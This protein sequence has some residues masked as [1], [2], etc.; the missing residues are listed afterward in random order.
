MFLSNLQQQRE[1][2]VT[3]SQKGALIFQT[4]SIKVNQL[5]LSPFLIDV[6]IYL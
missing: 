1:T 6:S 5:T 2:K 4:R 3:V